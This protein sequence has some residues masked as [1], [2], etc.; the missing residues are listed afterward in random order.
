VALVDILI[1]S[2]HVQ[3]AAFIFHIK[4]TYVMFT[5]SMLY[6]FASVLF[7]AC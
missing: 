5:R 6:D 4:K 7:T 2:A 3:E 1:K